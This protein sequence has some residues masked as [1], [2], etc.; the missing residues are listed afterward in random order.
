MLP[1]NQGDGHGLPGY[2]TIAFGCG[3]KQEHWQRPYGLSGVGQDYFG[4]APTPLMHSSRAQGAGLLSLFYHV[5]KE[6]FVAA[7]G[8]DVLGWDQSEWEQSDATATVGWS[9][10]AMQFRDVPRL[11]CRMLTVLLHN[12]R[13][14]IFPHTRWFVVAVSAG[15]AQTGTFVSA[16]SRCGIRIE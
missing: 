15:T 5:I 14:A 1:G 8:P 4:S 3:T 2:A 7:G 11:E 9:S 16:A 10:V 6:A 12:Y 13:P